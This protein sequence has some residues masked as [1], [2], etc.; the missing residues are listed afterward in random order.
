[1][2]AKLGAPFQSGKLRQA[3]IDEVGVDDATLKC[4]LCSSC[5]VRR[6][7]S[8]VRVGEAKA[9]IRGWDGS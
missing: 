7:S 8:S 1:M 2:S 9:F 6:S 4:V 3:E 5:H